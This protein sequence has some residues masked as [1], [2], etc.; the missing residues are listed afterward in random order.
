MDDALEAWTKSLST[1]TKASLAK[2]KWIRNQ[3]ASSSEPY[4]IDSC[5]DALE[6]MDDVADEAYN[7]A[8]EKLWWLSGEIYVSEDVR[9]TKEKV[10]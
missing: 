9:W 2:A 7:K 3:E 10:A 6:A 8:Y 5:M 1:K 4:S